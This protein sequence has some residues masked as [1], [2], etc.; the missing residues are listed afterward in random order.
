MKKKLLAIVLAL[1][2]II[3]ISYSIDSNKKVT[4]IETKKAERATSSKQKKEEA[5]LKKEKEKRIKE[6]KKIISNLSKK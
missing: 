4:N 5:K 3:R 2:S 6:A 1:F